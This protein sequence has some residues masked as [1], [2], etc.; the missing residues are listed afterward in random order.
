VAPR[1]GASRFQVRLLRVADV[2]LAPVLAL[3]LL[4][5][6]VLRRARLHRT[7]VTRW[8]CDNIGVLPVVDHYYEPLVIPRR[9]LSSSCERNLPGIDLRIDAQR[10]LLERLQAFAPE[11]ARLIELG[12]FETN[13]GFFGRTDAG[14]LYAMIRQ[15]R[16]AR[17]IEV[18]SGYS[19]IV[20]RAALARNALDGLPA[21]HICVEP[22]ENDWLESLGVE[23]DRRRVE[24]VPMSRFRDLG[25]GDMLIID[26]SHVIR[27]QGDVLYLLL[28]VLPSLAPGVL[29]HVHD[30]FTPAD[31]PREWIDDERRLWNEQYLLEA[32]LQCS[33]RYRVHLAVHWLGKRVPQELERVV[34]GTPNGGSFWL[35]VACG[36]DAQSS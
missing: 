17:L 20:V 28:E 30:V 27:P 3:G 10:G 29:V 6:R 13:N 14:V 8:L 24:H 9:H 36:A 18:G 23:V 33:S 34:G 12:E 21:D 22:F 26:S 11:Y 16:P 32:L 5:A 25:P 19:T 4:A 2:V 7:P 31:Y 1:T 15:H 35:G